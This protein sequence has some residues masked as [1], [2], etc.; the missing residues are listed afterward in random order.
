MPVWIIG[1]APML[2]DAN[3]PER[4]VSD[5]MQF[6]GPGGCR[7]FIFDRSERPIREADS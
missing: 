4:V 5:Y 2:A 1:R 6:T 7:K 3:G